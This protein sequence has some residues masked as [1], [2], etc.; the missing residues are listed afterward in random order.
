MNRKRRFLSGRNGPDSLS[1]AISLFACVLLILSMFAGGIVSSVL[2]LLALLSLIG[3]YYRILS[4]NI[5]RRSRENDRFLQL[6]HPITDFQSRRRARRR[7][8]N[9]YRFFKCPQCGTVLRVPK[10]KGHIRITCK[11]CQ[12]IFEE[13][14]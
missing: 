9:L 1:I 4:K 10:G 8:K 2:W 11:N 13:N 5:A 6:I 12:C 14:S 7:Q 3:S